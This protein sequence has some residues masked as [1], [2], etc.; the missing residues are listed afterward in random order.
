M[1]K[2]EETEALKELLE[3][4]ALKASPELESIKKSMR[5]KRKLMDEEG[6][7]F[8][9]ED[10]IEPLMEEYQQLLKRL[11]ET[12][13]ALRLVQ[14]SLLKRRTPKS[15]IVIQ[16][17]GRVVDNHRLGIERY[18]GK[19]LHVSLRDKDMIKIGELSKSDSIGYY[20][21]QLSKED[22]Q[23][24]KR[25]NIDNLYLVVVDEDGKILEDFQSDPISDVSK[26]PLGSSIYKDIEWTLGDWATRESDDPAIALL[27]GAS[28]LCDILTYYQSLYA[29]EA[30]LRTKEWRES[31]SQLK[32]L[33][34]SQLAGT[35]SDILIPY[36]IIVVAGVSAEFKGEYLITG[37]THTMTDYNYTQSFA[38]K[39]SHFETV[40]DQYITHTL[41]HSC[42][43]KNLKKN[44]YC[45]NCGAQL[46]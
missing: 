1:N 42:G 13:Q 40:F 27:E 25:K 21:L 32:S 33:T 22:L 31:I 19:Q 38:L 5:A 43:H 39:G 26:I 9:H 17:H 28:L 12:V 10:I 29:N 16:I 2:E 14:D 3:V 18:N 7:Q 8:T 45:R 35:D 20:H 34:Q 11:Q 30:Y 24:L 23:F 46:R 41:C 36:R 37:V 15:A 4:I 44:R 6:R